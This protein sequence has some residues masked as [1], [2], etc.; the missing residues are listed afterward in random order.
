MKQLLFH[1][2]AALA[3]LAGP[4]L[5]QTAAPVELDTAVVTANRTP[6]PADR[7]GAQVTVLDQ[8]TI[9]AEQTPILSDL[10]ARTPGVSVSRNGGVGAS[11]QL[12]IRGAETDQTVVLIDG[13][14]LNDPSSTGGG[15]NF[16]NL[17]A[18]DVAR[19]EVLRGAQS[20]LWGSQAI[21]G[22]VDI[23]TAEPKAPLETSVDAEGGGNGTAYVHGGVG[24]KTD[25]ASWRASAG[26]LTTDGISAFDQARGGREPDG[27]RNQGA[28]GK[29]QVML[30]DALSVDLRAVYSR[31]RNDFDGFPA[32]NYVF[33]DDSEYGTTMDFV[34]YAGANLALMGGKLSNRLAFTYTDTERHNYDPTQAVT[35]H[36]FDAVGYNRRFEYQGAWAV[37]QG[38]TAVFG[39]EAERSWM[40][41]AS[42]SSFDPS[43]API[44]RHAR[45]D[46]LYGQLQ[47]EV[48]PGLSLAGGLRHDDDGDFGG[49]TVG[50]ASAAWSLNDGATVL[51]ASWGEGFKAPT[52]YELGSPYGDAHLA[53]EQ[54]RSW[55]AG[56]EQSLLQGRVTV[57]AA[58]FERHTRDQIDFVSC[59]SAATSPLC[60]GAAGL[61]RFGYY[62]NTTLTEA[63]GVELQGQ[64]TLA[65][66]LTL[67]GGYTW[68]PTR[69]ESPGSANLGKELNRRPTHEAEAE[70]AYLWPMG[71]TTTLAVH[72][73]GASFDDVANLAPLKGVTLVDVRA[74]YPLTPQVGLYARVE[75]LTAQ[76]YETILNYGQP[77]RTASVG[78]RARF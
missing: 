34:G 60:V 23:I 39:A 66:G 13:V 49:H 48:A 15:Y 44:R 45:L 26:Y 35:N 19:I 24:G 50:Q 14:K 68:A 29:A 17:L 22:V 1:T 47:G 77:G 18:G 53:P 27:Y 70:L 7:V 46:G 41:S 43:P 28:A 25:R 3:L 8:K 20:V 42:P 57:S 5:A 72:Y 33:A 6:V 74:D 40:R 32:P 75:N 78:V 63:H 58:W 12:R 16:A 4:A 2:A 59:P 76:S 36:T 71:I 55:D 56:V 21:G 31:G 67:S 65:K 62:A 10:L 51:R 11:T 73:R 61:P 54:A 64:A 9:E 37:A 30:S 38:W 52:L 69:N